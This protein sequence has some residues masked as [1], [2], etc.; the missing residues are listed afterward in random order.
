MLRNAL[1]KSASETKINS[2]QIFSTICKKF[3]SIL[4]IKANEIKNKSSC[5]SD[6]AGHQLLRRLAIAGFRQ[7]PSV[8]DA[9]F[10]KQPSDSSKRKSQP[11]INCYD[12]LPLLASDSIPLSQTLPSC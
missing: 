10:A 5:S 3:V 12:D 6:K 9:L 1:S 8:A 11:A 2:L 4:L 7:Y